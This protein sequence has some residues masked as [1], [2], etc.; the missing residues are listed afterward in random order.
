MCYNVGMRL[1]LASDNLG[2]FADIL[3]ELVGNNKKALII[4]N[5]RDYRSLDDRKAIVDED[6]GMLEKCGFDVVELDLR[7][8]FSNAPKLRE[9]IDNY[10]PGLVFAVGGNLYALATALHLSGMGNILRDDLSQ[11]KYVYGGYSA[12]SMVASYDLLNYLDSYGR[13]SSDRLEQTIELYGEAFTDGLGLINEYVTPH[14]DREKF[15]LSCKE[16]EADISG[17]G[18]TPIVLNDTDV[19]VMNGE[20]IDVLRKGN[21][22]V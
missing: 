16:A 19:V 14:A 5:A 15:R 11:D 1:Y 18:L 13:R 20:K 3:I 17:R 8:Y 4:S 6:V 22:L 2:G 10:K 21:R 9:Y 7:K 12:G